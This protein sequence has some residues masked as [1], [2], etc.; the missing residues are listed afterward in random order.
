MFYVGDIISRITSKSMLSVS[1]MAIGTLSFFSGGAVRAAAHVAQPPRRMERPVAEAEAD[2]HLLRA[3]QI[4]PALR[5]SGAGRL[6]QG[7]GVGAAERQ[8]TRSTKRS[9]K[10]CNHFPGRLKDCASSAR[11]NER[12]RRARGWDVGSYC[13]QKVSVQLMRERGGRY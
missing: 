12:G 11:R 3:G 4:N 1:A 7:G 6:L 2:G 5:G 10:D 9:E 8:A 13:F